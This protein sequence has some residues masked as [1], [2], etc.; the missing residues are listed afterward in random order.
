MCMCLSVG[1]CVCLSDKFAHR[2]RE[3]PCKGDC[4][5]DDDATAVTRAVTI[6]GLTRSGYTCACRTQHAALFTT[7]IRGQDKSINAYTCTSIY[8]YTCTFTMC[9]NEGKNI[10]MHV[11]ER[12][13]RIQDTQMTRGQVYLREVTYT[14]LNE[15]SVGDSKQEEDH[16]M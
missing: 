11:F 15:I 1:V 2:L 5:A 10:Y 7:I 16:K 13:P 6:K 14:N 4:S 9:V 8:V 12:Q 3:L